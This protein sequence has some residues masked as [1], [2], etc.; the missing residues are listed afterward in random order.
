VRDDFIVFAEDL[1]ACKKLGAAS[2]V[3]K[4]LTFSSFAKAFA[5]TFHIRRAAAGPGAQEPALHPNRREISD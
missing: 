5:D 1:E 2:F 3:A 4:P